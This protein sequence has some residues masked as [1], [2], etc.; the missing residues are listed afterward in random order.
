[1]MIA[2]AKEVS[3]FWFIE[4]LTGHILINHSN[5]SFFVKIINKF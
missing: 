2:F 1:M 4:G 5:S 3:V